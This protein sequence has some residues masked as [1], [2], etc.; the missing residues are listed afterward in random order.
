VEAMNPRRRDDGCSPPLN[1]V[2]GQQ[3]SVEAIIAQVL[4]RVRARFIR[5][6]G[7]GDR[8]FEMPAEIFVADD[9]A[10]AR[11]QH[12]LRLPQTEFVVPCRLAIRRVARPGAAAVHRKAT[13]H[14]YRAWMP[15]L[16]FAR[17]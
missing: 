1:H 5:I 10:G 8:I 11:F 4:L 16:A 17:F 13:R 2:E 3:Q 14:R 15:A 6:F 7:I 12:N 9:L